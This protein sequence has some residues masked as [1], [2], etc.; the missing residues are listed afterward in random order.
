MASDN[1]TRTIALL[2]ASGAVPPGEQAP[3]A[4][5]ARCLL[6]RSDAAIL[7]FDADGKIAIGTAI[8][9]VITIDPTTGDIYAPGSII[10]ASVFTGDFEGNPTVTGNL[11][12]TGSLAVGGSTVTGNVVVPSTKTLT[13]SGAFDVTLTVTAGTNVTLPTTGTLATTTAVAMKANTASPTFTGTVTLPAAVN[14]AALP[15]VAG[16][17]GTLYIDS[18]VVKVAP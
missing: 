18:G 7:T 1:V 9:T 5:V 16:A 4:S 8:G 10:T 3:I 2:I 13:V 11:T 17:A 15:L 6:N 12:V 14:V